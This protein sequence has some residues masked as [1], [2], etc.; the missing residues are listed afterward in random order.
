[1]KFSDPFDPSFLLPSRIRET[2]AWRDLCLAIQKVFGEN[3]VDAREYFTRSRDSMKFRRGQFIRIQGNLFRIEQ[4]QH[5]T[6]SYPNAPLPE[7]LTVTDGNGRY[8]EL[9]GIHATNERELLIRNAASLGFNVIADRLNDEDFSRLV[10]SLGRYYSMRGTKQ[11]VNFIGFI[12]NINLKVSQ[13]WA[14]E[15]TDDTYGDFY[16]EPQ[17]LSAIDDP[18]NGT[19]FPTSHYRV[20]YDGDIF[21]DFADSEFIELFLKFAPIHVVLESF[22][23]V[24]NSPHIG[25]FIT[26]FGGH[27]TEVIFSPA[28]NPDIQYIMTLHIVQPFVGD[29]EVIFSPTNT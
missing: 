1:M 5:H 24:I 3:I 21:E 29:S 25:M 7:V 10:E 6:N 16:P 12:K 14:E 9:S 2:P 27:E 13:L 20:E 17:G 19:W 26:P 23:A 11:F 4:V 8:Y 15:S 18:V 28:N 22:G